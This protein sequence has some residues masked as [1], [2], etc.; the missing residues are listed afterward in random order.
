MKSATKIAPEP[1][2]YTAQEIHQAAR[3]AEML[4]QPEGESTYGTVPAIEVRWSP[5]QGGDANGYQLVVDVLPECH[6]TIP[7]GK[8][9]LPARVA[10]ELVD[11]ANYLEFVAAYLREQADSYHEAAKRDFW[12]KSGKNAPKAKAT[13][14]AK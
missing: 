6:R 13:A 4:S 9:P 12:R 7:E 1:R 5:A 10:D 3:E 8:S 11:L 14:K 2:R